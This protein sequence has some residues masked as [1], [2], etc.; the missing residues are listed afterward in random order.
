MSEITEGI[1]QVLHVYFIVALLEFFVS[2]LL[3]I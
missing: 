1:F 2:M 3:N